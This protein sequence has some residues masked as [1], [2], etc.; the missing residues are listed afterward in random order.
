MLS[1]VDLGQRSADAWMKSI[2]MSSEPRAAHAIGRSYSLSIKKKLPSNETSI[3]PSILYNHSYLYLGYF[4]SLHVQS[5]PTSLSLHR[6]DE[7]PRSRADETT[8]W[9]PILR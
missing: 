2:R 1:F 8:P 6:F 7:G 4:I 9:G 5:A 3:N